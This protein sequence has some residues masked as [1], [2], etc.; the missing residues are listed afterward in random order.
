[1]VWERFAF[2]F[3]AFASRSISAWISLRTALRRANASA[4]TVGAQAPKQWEQ[5]G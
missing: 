1:V 4:L 3:F 2:V 5:G